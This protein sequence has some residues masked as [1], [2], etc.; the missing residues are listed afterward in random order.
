MAELIGSLSA[1]DH[2][3]GMAVVKKKLQAQ[4]LGSIPKVLPEPSSHS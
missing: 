1:Q 4:R 3:A 2:N